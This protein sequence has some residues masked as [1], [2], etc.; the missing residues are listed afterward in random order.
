MSSREQ[1]TKGG[2]LDRGLGEGLTNPH[3]KR[4]ACYEML[5]KASELVDTL[6]CHRQRKMDMGFGTWNVRIL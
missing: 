4:P 1:P 3:S 6:E 5:H 2:P